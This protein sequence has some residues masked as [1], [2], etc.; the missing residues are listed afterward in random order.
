MERELLEL[1]QKFVLLP[2]YGKVSQEHHVENFLGDFMVSFSSI[3]NF[4]TDFFEGADGKVQKQERESH[5]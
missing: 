2:S 3:D 5:E 1:Q 4:L